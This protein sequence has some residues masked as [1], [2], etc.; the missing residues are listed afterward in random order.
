VALVKQHSG[1]AAQMNDEDVIREFLIESNENLS[2]LDNEIVELERRPKDAHLLASI[3]RTMH[4]L[5]GTC[6]FLA[7]GKLERIAHEAETI[8]SQLRAGDRELNPE[9]TSLVL[10]VIDATRAILQ[11]IEATGGEGDN[12][13]GNL[14]ERL[15]RAA[16]A[17]PQAFEPA[18]K[19]PAAE[20]LPAMVA[21]T[22]EL[23]AAAQAQPRGDPARNEETEHRSAA[24]DSAIRV[25][26][27]LLDKLMNLVGEL[28]LARNQILQFSARN[29][30]GAW[31]ATSQ[32]LNLITTELQE[33]VMKTRMQPIGVVWNKLPRV[34]RDL[35]HSL[36]KQIRLETDGASTELDKTIIEAIK[37]PLTHLVRN[38]CDHGIERPDV[39]ILSGK[40]PQGRILLRAYHEGGQVN[41]EITDDGAGVDLAR[42]KQKAVERG[43]LREDQL[44][45]MSEREILNLIF[46]PGFSTAE[47]V[48]N[49]SGR[50]VGMDVVRSNIE[51]IG[52]VVDLSNRFGEGST[53][54]VKIP[55]TLAIIPGLVVTS[56]T[57]RF[58]IPQVS[59]LELVRLEGEAGKQ[60]EWIHGTPVLR[61]R[62][63]LLPIAYLN[64]VLELGG[65]T[66]GEVLNIVVLQAEDRQFGL[67]VD[68]ISDTQEIV[69]KPLAKQLKGLA[70]YAGATIMGDGKVALILD[71]VGVGQRSGVLSSTG[72]SRADA[73]VA[74]H[75]ASDI[76]R[77]VLFRAGAFERLV[78]PLSLVARL[79]EF[80]Q[81]KI[82][83]SGGGRVVQYR[84]RILPLVVSISVLDPAASDAVLE[85]DPLQVIVFTEGERSIGLVVDQIVDIVEGNIAVRRQGTRRGLLGSAVVAGQV[86][87]FLDLHA[88]LQAVAPDWFDPRRE[89]GRWEPAP[90][91]LLAEASPLSR[92]LLRTGLEMAG[93]RV[94]EAASTPAA[95]Q[96]L[97]QHAADLLMASEN[98]PPA[99]SA[100]LIEAV[101]NQ[102]R[103]H[104][105][106]AI[107]L[108]T[109]GAPPEN[110]VFEEYQRKFDWPGMLRSLERLS[111]AAAGPPASERK[112]VPDK[113][114]VKP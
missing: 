104:R 64:R 51:K 52:G 103:E 57:A 68:G 77:L 88:V 106:P 34:V 61:R 112:K 70:V 92:G 55:L 47:R 24:A 7:F 48:T 90:T 39:R 73:A 8:F 17:T 22:P 14:I 109:S 100:E 67:V 9:L 87:D 28:V 54:R 108:T 10:E 78:V 16:K 23:E 97:A 113:A 29:D 82:E 50:G 12:D 46:R 79:E 95:L 65:S 94:L 99:G 62:G 83:R 11:A 71:A 41:I 102:S 107:C 19:A 74:G 111:A 85:R 38:C 43:L 96:V 69:V 56:G 66:A 31:N 1:E 4:T 60:I 114:E 98:L 89:G 15:K 2:R 76:E 105:L 58:V 84:G 93:Y 72:H 25:D 20:V 49:V 80:D 44:G 40:P 6:G 26:V 33:G 35:A 37:D 27:G 86:T 75:A 59:L 36:G 45:R 110:G 21:Q 101:R 91:V 32:R 81:A 5:K 53:V 63:T 13:C 30:G 42:V 18:P 3:F